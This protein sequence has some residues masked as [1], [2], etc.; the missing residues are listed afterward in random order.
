MAPR[1]RVIQLVKFRCLIIRYV[2]SADIADAVMILVEGFQFIVK[3]YCFF[4]HMRDRIT[5]VK[6]AVWIVA[7]RPMIPYVGINVRARIIPI[8]EHMIDSFR[9]MS[10]LPCPFMRFA[11]LKCPK[12]VNK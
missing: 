4:I 8:M 3:L 12:A 6:V 7:I 5:C 1:I 11:E 9:F 10:V 2:I